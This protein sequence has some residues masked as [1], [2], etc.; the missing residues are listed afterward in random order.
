MTSIRVGLNNS[1]FCCFVT[2]IQ[3][4]WTRVKAEQI[5]NINWCLTARQLRSIW[6]TV[7]EENPPR[8]LNKIQSVNK[9]VTNRFN[10]VYE[11]QRNSSLTDS[12]FLRLPIFSISLSDFVNSFVEFSSHFIFIIIF[13]A[14][15]LGC[16]IQHN[17]L[18]L[19][20]N[21]LCPACQPS[22]LQ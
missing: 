20:L 8:Q 13:L 1:D 15:Q 16:S 12:H 14:L 7:V 4:S 9:Q 18:S 22:N 2:V 6:A 11:V 21:I 17:I 5:F 19:T 3:S 10:L